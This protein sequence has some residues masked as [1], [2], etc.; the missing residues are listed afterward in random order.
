MSNGVEN[1][2]LCILSK[3]AIPTVQLTTVIIL[4]TY[5]KLISADE[6]IV[7]CHMILFHIMRLTKMNLVTSCFQ[8]H[9]MKFFFGKMP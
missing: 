9:V 3:S 5:T 2:Y 8:F 7:T 1:V 6:V 4:F